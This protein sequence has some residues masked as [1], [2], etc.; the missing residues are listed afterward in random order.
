[1]IDFF[2]LAIIGA[3]P[4]GMDAALAASQS[5]LKTVVI[6]SYPQPGGQY[7]MQTPMKF[8]A[9]K[10]TESEIEGKEIVEKFNKN[11][12]TKYLN[13]LTWAIFKEEDK[14]GWLIALY[15]S[16]C[17]NYIRSK[18]LILA[19]GAYD[20]PVA[21]P[22]WTMPGVITCGAALILL[23][24]QRIVPGHRAL[25]TGTGPLLLSVA[26]H[27]ID[28]GVEVVAVCES[29]RLF[30]RGLRYGITMLG[31]KHRLFEG[32][33]YLK[34]IIASKTP[35]IMGSSI[36]RAQGKDKV[37]SAEISRIDQNGSPIKGS[38]EQFDVDLVISGY[39][40]TPNTGLARMIGC[41]MDYL[42]GKG[43]WV[44]QRDEYF[45]SSIP[46]VYIIGDGAGIGGA[47][48]ARLEGQLAAISVALE[49]GNLTSSQADIKYKLLKPKL[50]NQH[51]FGHV[52]EDLFSP[53]SGLIDL[54]TDDTIICRCEEITVGEVK[55]AVSQGARTIAEVKMITRV[56]M[57]NCQGRMCE[58]SVTGLIIN[59]L[60]RELETPQSIGYYSVR[61]PLHPLPQSF[62]AQAGLEEDQ[63]L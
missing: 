15:G 59:T 4:G 39:S 25:I 54:A 44:P 9:E 13:A 2:D 49:N 57:G 8:E 36:V 24:T 41:K 1:M 51:R 52:L 17:P 55:A 16:T 32:A 12:V 42:P 60:A 30:P 62:L 19:N 45:Q 37:E 20:T 11:I 7:F 63:K 33:G 43:G 5:G 22:G 29:S 56:G 3:G 28:A 10:E 38:E 35:Y 48:N 46:G 26:A 34:K 6:D 40:L 61:P 31:H 50:A 53:K 23:K 21:F 27:L 18:F 58:H 14:S 47:E